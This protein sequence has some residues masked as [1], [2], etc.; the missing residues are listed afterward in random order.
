MCSSD[1]TLTVFELDEDNF[2]ERRYGREMYAAGIGLVFKQR[3]EL[4]KR[5]GVVTTGTSYRMELTGYGKR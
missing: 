1:L 3:D 5:N 4:G 2:V